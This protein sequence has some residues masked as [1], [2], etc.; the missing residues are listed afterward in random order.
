MLVMELGMKIGV[1]PSVIFGFIILCPNVYLLFTIQI[2]LSTRNKIRHGTLTKLSHY[3]WNYEHFMMELQTGELIAI[4]APEFIE[5][6]HSLAL[7]ANYVRCVV[8]SMWQLNQSSVDGILRNC[9]SG[10]IVERR[11][12]CAQK[13]CGIVWEN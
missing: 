5:T 3:R 13:C 2:R 11:T 4:R 7:P 6:R 1:C 12:S 10:G 9:D 8:G